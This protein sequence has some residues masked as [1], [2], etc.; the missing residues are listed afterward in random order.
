[1]IGC[2]TPCAPLVGRASSRANSSVVSVADTNRR[3]WSN[4]TYVWIRSHGSPT[5]RP[6]AASDNRTQKF[7]YYARRP[8]TTAQHNRPP[9]QTASTRT[10]LPPGPCPG[11]YTRSPKYP[12]LLSNPR[13]DMLG[14]ISPTERSLRHRQP[15]GSPIRCLCVECPTLAWGDDSP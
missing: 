11:F 10:P 2:V 14:A 8:R 5:P 6:S 4:A 9:E 3:A 13:T 1:M 12:L 15:N 7:R